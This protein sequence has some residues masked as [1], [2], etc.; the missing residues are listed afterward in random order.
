MLD[1]TTRK[2]LRWH[3]RRGMWELDMMLMPF[4]DNCFEQLDDQG[5]RDYQRLLSSE[6][7]DLFLWLMKRQPCDDESLQPIANEII[8]YARHRDEVNVRPV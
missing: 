6:D 7:Q 8:S 2:R 3:S 1:E 5:Q 4:F